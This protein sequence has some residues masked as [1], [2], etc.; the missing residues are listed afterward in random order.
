MTLAF[1]LLRRIEI[2]VIHLFLLL[3]ETMKVVMKM[4]CFTDSMTSHTTASDS[5]EFKSFFLPDKSLKQNQVHDLTY[6]T[7]FQNQP[8]IVLLKTNLVPPS[9]T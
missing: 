8:E 1:C 6:D 7:V 2:S 4:M 5:S 3:H 9:P